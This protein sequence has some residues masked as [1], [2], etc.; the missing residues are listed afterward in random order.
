MNYYATVYILMVD[1]TSVPYITITICKYDRCHD[2]Y[3]VTFHMLVV[4]SVYMLSVMHAYELLRQLLR[5]L[6]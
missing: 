5:K 6:Q 3:H 1:I 2:N 4:S